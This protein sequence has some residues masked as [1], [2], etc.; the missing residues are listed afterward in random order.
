MVMMA[1]EVF[2]EFVPSMV[3]AAGNFVNDANGFK[4]GQISIRRALG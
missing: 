1:D 4:V 3:V 2:V